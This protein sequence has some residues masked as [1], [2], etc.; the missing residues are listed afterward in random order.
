MKGY[1]T[2]ATY[3]SEKLVATISRDEKQTIK[4]VNRPKKALPL[5]Q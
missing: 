4:K 3:A 5:P 2:D 1:G